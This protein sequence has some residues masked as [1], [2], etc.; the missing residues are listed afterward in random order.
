MCAAN[1]ALLD[2]KWQA[3]SPVAKAATGVAIGAGMS[4]T[5]DMAEAGMLVAQ[6]GVQLYGAL[7]GMSS[8]AL[9][10]TGTPLHYP[11]YSAPAM[12]PQAVVT[13]VLKVHCAH[14]YG[15]HS[16]DQSVQICNHKHECAVAQCCCKISDT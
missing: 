12:K 6:V 10:H 15:M 16:K 3:D 2:A 4:S 13:V 8:L 5:E 14:T 7:Q 11:Y 9:L 1:E